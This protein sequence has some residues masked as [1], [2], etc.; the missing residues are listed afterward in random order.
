MRIVVLDGYTLNP[1]DLSWD[2]LETIGE[3]EVHDRTDFTDDAIVEAAGGADVVLTNKTP[4]S[5]SVIGRLSSLRYIGVLATGFNVVDLEAAK[6][7]GMP[8]TNIPTYGTD[9]V[10]QMTFAHL[11]NL[12]HHVAEHSDNVRT[13]GWARSPDFCYWLHAQIE[14]A[15]RTLGIVG[16]GRIGR[17][18]GQIANALGMRVIAHDLHRGGEPDWPGFAWREIDELLAE[19]DVVTLHCPLTPGN[20]GM[21]N[22]QRLARMKRS[23]FL[24]NMSR[25]PLVVDADLATA[26][27]EGVI[28]GA[29]I[30]V[31]EQEPPAA[32]NPLYDAPNVT[33]TP[34]I[35]WATKEA[36]S[37]LLSTAVENV[38]AFLDGTPRNVVNGV[39]SSAPLQ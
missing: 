39:G 28:A 38:R 27:R 34:H 17:R 14:L 9:S 19:S 24:L 32:D 2:G 20:T 21:M 18:V 15:G 22:A 13:G 31:L 16:F 37:R 33:I 25:G 5:A 3:V 6:A 10:A 35:A 30:D 29:G 4:L 7:R 1:G 23:A 12:C 8:V 11:L 36:R 26:L